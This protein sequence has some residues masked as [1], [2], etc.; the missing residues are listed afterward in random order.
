MKTLYAIAALIFSVLASSSLVAA[1]AYTATN[2]G[3]ASTH[4]SP[5]AVD[6]G[7]RVAGVF[8]VP[9]KPPQLHAFFWS[10]SGGVQDLGTL[11]GDD[12]G[13]Y[14]LNASGQVVGQANSVAQAPDQAF[15]WTKSAGMI[16]L[17]NL[18]G[19]QSV[20]NAINSSGQV[21]GQAALA[22]GFTHA[23]FWSNSGGLQDLGTLSGG[24]QSG[25]NAINS[26]GEIAGWGNIGS[27]GRALTGTVSGG[28]V[29][30][31]IV[32]NCGAT[33]LG[34]NDPGEVVGWF[35]NSSSCGFTSHGFSW[36]QS[37]G[38]K[39]LGV[40]TGGQYSFA[41]AVNS[42]GQ[43]VGTGDSGSSGVVALMWTPD[44]TLYDLN[45]LIAPGIARIL[46][47]ANAINS[48]G[49]IVVDATAKNGLGNYALLL[50]PRMSAAVTS[51]LNPSQAGQSVTLS[52][53]VTS[54]AGAPPNG[55]NVVFKQ[56]STVLATVGLTN[57]VASFTTSTLTA[58]QHKIVATY[59][60]DG[61]Y[62]PSKSL[63]FTQM[64]TK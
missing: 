23:F 8:Q 56:G 54:I 55:E 14:G 12:S 60:G 33:A 10:K 59:A 30:L 19:A 63:V 26:S 36:T 38:V 34:I 62:A 27:S 15:L 6:S 3:T 24:K 20:A 18:G 42:S 45:T 44:G 52:A 25:A 40:L 39:D 41:Y 43:I 2:I 46:V 49:Q 28:L 47:A 16:A 64:V 58:G 11:G 50:T 57:G 21:A 29:D 17:G 37:G 32:A 53:A 1:Q 13:A 9:T 48:S 51:S 22:N 61:V 35:N 31:G 4:P 7:G 5:R